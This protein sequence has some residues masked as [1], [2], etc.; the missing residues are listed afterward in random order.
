MSRTPRRV[1]VAVPVPLA[2]AFDYLA[3]EGGALPQIGCRVRVPFGRGERIGV[4]VEHPA[5]TN[6]RA[7][8]LK[9]VRSVLDSTPAI[10]NELFA[11]LRFVV[12]DE[13]HQIVDRLQ[14]LADIVP[15][16]QCRRRLTVQ[17]EFHV[18]MGDVAVSGVSREGDG[19]LEGCQLD[20]QLVAKSNW[21]RSQERIHRQH[22]CSVIGQT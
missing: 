7:S 10:G 12:L 1:S 11:S 18:P 6:V 21:S 17:R 5:T 3:P 14:R 15:A 13:V 22:V 19:I 8:S 16:P 9:R 20:L 4:V 2:D